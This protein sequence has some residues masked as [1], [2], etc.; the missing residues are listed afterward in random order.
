MYLAI[1]PKIVFVVY[2]GKSVLVRKH[3]SKGFNCEHFYWFWVDLDFIKTVEQVIFFL[4][5]TFFL[6]QFPSCFTYFKFPSYII[7]I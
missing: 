1:A 7:L 5:I 4:Y 6:D 3:S 2:T